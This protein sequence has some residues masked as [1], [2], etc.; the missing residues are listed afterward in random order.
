MKR[1]PQQHAPAGSFLRPAWLFLFLIGVC[2]AAFYRVPFASYLAWDDYSYLL[3][4]KLY[5]EPFAAFLHHIMTPGAIAGERLFIPLAYLSFLPDKLLGWNATV[6]HGINLCFHLIN[7]ALLF[8]LLWRLKIPRNWAIWAVAL[9]LVHPYSVETVA[10]VFA[11]RDLIAICCILAAALCLPRGFWD[12]SLLEHPDFR[13][14]WLVMRLAAAEVI[15]LLG[16]LAKPNAAFLFPLFVCWYIW[17]FRRR[18]PV[19]CLGWFDL[20]FYWGGILWLAILTLNLRTGAAMG[21]ESGSGLIPWEMYQIRLLQMPAV[22]MQL[23]KAFFMVTSPQLFYLYRHLTPEMIQTL[24]WILFLSV[25]GVCCL[26]VIHSHRFRWLFGACVALIIPCVALYLAQDRVFYFG[27]RYMYPMLPLLGMLAAWSI[28][29]VNARNEFSTI[30]LVCV[31]A[32]AAV[33]THEQTK[34]WHDNATLGQSALVH[35]PGNTLAANLLAIGLWDRGRKEQ[36][37][38]VLR[39]ILGVRPDYVTGWNNLASFLQHMS[40]PDW[41]VCEQRSK[42]AKWGYE[43]VLVLQIYRLGRQNPETLRRFV[44]RM[45]RNGYWP[46]IHWQCPRLAFVMGNFAQRAGALGLA[47]RC[48]RRAVTLAPTFAPAWYNWAILARRTGAAALAAKRF[49][50]AAR[51]EG[52]NSSTR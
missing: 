12:C 44:A 51:L 23:A 17:R 21:G 50:I 6:S 4:N 32:I 31:V 9:L 40:S 29:S 48:Y 19:T 43:Y 14:R 39:E 28:H 5:D 22:I 46:P 25:S 38:G 20:T 42:I 27:S 10:W 36:A 47:D 33:R 26:A 49:R 1:D 52:R 45:Q 8:L 13:G 24:P 15:F 37:V 7:G 30:L 41:K 34:A 3:H 16:L 18:L 2:I 11:R 35:D